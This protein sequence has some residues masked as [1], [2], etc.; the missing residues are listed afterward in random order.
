M[1]LNELIQALSDPTIYPGAS[2]VEI[3]QTH[4]SAV[5]I[6]NN[7]VYKLKKP[8]DFGFLDYQT[9]DR[10]RLMCH[11]EV[12]LNRRLTHG[13]YLGVERLVRREGRLRIGGEGKLVDYLVHMRRLPEDGSLRSRVLSESIRAEEI[14][15]VARK[16]ARFHSE[17]HQSQEIDR[18]GLP[19]AIGRNVEENLQQIGRYIGRTLTREGYEFIASTARDTLADHRLTFHLRVYDGMIRDGH[20][21]IR[22][23]HVYLLDEI[24]IIDCIEFNDRIRY[25]DVASDIG[26]LAMDLDAMNRPDLS[27]RLIASYA[28]ETGWDVLTVLDFYR[29]YRAVIRGKVTSFRLD[30]PG[31][32]PGEHYATIREARR[33]FHLAYRYSA[34]DR[35]PRLILTSGLTGTGKSTLA[36]ALGDVLPATVIDSDTTRKEIAGLPPTSRQH[37]AYGTGLYSP[38]ISAQTYATLLERAAVMMARGQTVILDATYIRQEDRLNARDLARERNATFLILDCQAP[39]PV[40][41]AR[42]AGREED[43]ERV[44][45]G[46]WEIYLAQKEE[47]EPIFGLTSAEVA[48]IDSGQPVSHQVDQVMAHLE[49]TIAGTAV[50]VPVR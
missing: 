22:A 14:D 25:G 36:R 32:D 13:V 8:V 38:K 20:G 24:H 30:E 41:R 9:L 7:D 47:A 49:R 27:D 5:F 3:R 11:L 48:H 23:E 12:Q 17:A 1:D 37:D 28:R 31:F 26:F 16:I 42:L 33:F 40:I 18:Y 46:R 2:H 43:L 35:G 4:A 19:S 10:R 34:G 50:P 39:E 29:A 45:D 44:S 6:T 15:A 21:D